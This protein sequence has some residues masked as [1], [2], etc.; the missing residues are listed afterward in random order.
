MLTPAH[1]QSIA[2]LAV[3]LVAFYAMARRG[4]AQAIAM[5]L[6]ASAFL[7]L[8]LTHAKEITESAFRDF[9]PVAILFTAVAVPA[10]MIERSN[11]FTWLGA[12]LGTQIGW[13]RLRTELAVHLLVFVLLLITFIAA[14][15]FHNITSIMVMV[16]ITITICS[17]YGIPTRW[18]LSGQLIASNLGGF[19]TSWGDTPNIIERT[20]WSLTNRDFTLEILPVNLGV[21][22]LLTIAVIPLTRSAMRDRID[23]VRIAIARAS[24]RLE[25]MYIV[26]DKRLLLVGLST[27]A[28]F[29]TLQ[30]VNRELELAA[31]AITIA[32]A[33]LADR[34]EDR[35]RSLQALDL[36]LYMVLGS[37][38]VLA[39]AVDKSLIGES[40]ARLVRDAGGAPFVIAISAYFGTLLTEAASWASATAPAVHVVNAS[41]A[42]AWSLGAG[43]CAGSSSL[44]TAAS[45]GLVL[46]SQS[47]RFAGHEVNFGRYLTFGL[48]ASLV[49]LVLYIMYFTIVR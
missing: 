31:A 25:R 39:R 27:L 19:S 18:L 40:L 20:A 15:L 49:M 38:F 2:M 46:W 12:A 9:G 35:L 5:P 34:P 13:L 16:P 43:I 30:W 17:Q 45:A 32:I 10:H 24:Q 6:A 11:A 33:V 36:D 42:G 26:V 37:I 14:A 29:I 22:G 4:V 47:R 8:S 44:L 28:L 3:L 48:P 41:H 21:L 23:N 1:F 7:A